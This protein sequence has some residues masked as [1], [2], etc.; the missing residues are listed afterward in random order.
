[1]GLIKKKT[2]LVFQPK[3]KM[4]IYGQ[5]GTGKTTLALSAPRPLVI[6]CDNGIHRVAYE[7][8]KDTVQVRSYEDVLAVLNEDLSDYDTIVIDT[9]GKL[10]DYMAEYI[11]AR[12]PR[13]ARGSNGQLT[14]QGYGERKGEFTALCKKVHMLNK[15]LVFVAHRQTQ[16]EGDNYKYVPL[17]GGSNY[18]SLVTELDLVGYLEVNGKSRVITFDPTD[19]NDGKNTCNLPSRMEL[20]NVVD[21]N[22]NGLDNTFLTKKVIEAY[23]EK[24]EKSVAD[25][26]AVESLVNS[27][28]ERLAKVVGADDLTGVYNWAVGL[29]HVGASKAQVKKLIA[30][31]SVEIKASYD[32]EQKK[33]VA[34]EQ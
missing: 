2:E 7:H 33:F 21:K 19:R 6:D 10:L 15:H 23:Q 8:I 1:M 22:G 26:K 25:K 17:F 34:N 18:D 14:L 20:D 12:N 13:M 4:L 29:E 5:A 9:G 31:K 28:K 16:Q 27:V 3:V 24:L 32:K 11:I 30:D